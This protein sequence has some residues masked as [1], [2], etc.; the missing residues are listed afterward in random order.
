MAPERWRNPPR[1]PLVDVFEG[2]CETM[3][4][5]WTPDDATLKEY[6]SFG[7][8]RG[9][10]ARFPADSPFDAVRFTMRGENQVCYTLEREYAPVK[11][12][13]VDALSGRLAA[14]ATV[15]AAGWRRRPKKESQP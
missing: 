14:Q 10:C 4:E 15:F 13:G 3:A 8:A 1:L 11:H 5:A 6:C 9:R 7:Y 12:G 2:V